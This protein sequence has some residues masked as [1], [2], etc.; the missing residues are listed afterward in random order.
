[1]EHFRATQGVLDICKNVDKNYSL[2]R[3]AVQYLFVPW[4]R[5]KNMHRWVRFA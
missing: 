2:R 1:M 3:S 4:C 5:I